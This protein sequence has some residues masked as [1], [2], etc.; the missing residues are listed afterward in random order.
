MKKP[1]LLMLVVVWEFLTA[2][3]AFIGL[4]AIAIL[5]FPDA[6]ASMWGSAIPG[7]IFALSVGILILISYIII[8]VTA[9]VGIIKDQ[10]WGRVLSIV[11]AAFTLI[12]IPVGTIISVLIII[13]LTR[14]DVTEYFRLNT[15]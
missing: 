8:S 13:Y 1:D 2:F 11:H 3:L 9:A 15:K 7:A 6:T 5:A 14:Q 12:A 10:E 4:L